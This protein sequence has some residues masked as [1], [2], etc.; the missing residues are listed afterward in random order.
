MPGPRINRLTNANVY[1]GNGSLLGK[2]EEMDLPDVKGVMSEHKALG[3]FGKMEFLSGFDKM[4]CKMK[5]N[6][7]YPATFLA[8]ADM[9][10]A[11]QI[12]LRGNIEEYTGGTRIS[13]KAYKVFLTTQFT[14]FPTGSFKAMD[15]VEFEANCAVSRVKVEF[16]GNEIFEFD[17]SANIYMVGG[18]D[19]LA[20]YRANLGI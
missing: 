7:F 11:V 4:T 10:S 15:N 8:V 18:V 17:A 20:Q 6:S 9:Y 13:Q 5:F 14:N 2:V 19:K 1:L 12:Q 16:D 3:L